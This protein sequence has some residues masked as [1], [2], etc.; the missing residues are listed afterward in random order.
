[1]EVISYTYKAVVDRI[2]DGDTFDAH[3]DLGFTVMVKVRFRLKGVD[4]PEIYS[5][6]TQAELE[7]GRAAAE[8]VSKAMP[9]G[10]EVLI[11]SSKMGAYNR[12]DADVTLPSGVDLAT[13]IK[14]GGFEKKSHY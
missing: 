13:L 11:K 10:T 2:I 7:H 12:Y 1:M 4:T 14:N 6:K 9:V 8:F 3:V 5:P